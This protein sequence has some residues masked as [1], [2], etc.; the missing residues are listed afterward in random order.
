VLAAAA[1]V[2][3]PQVPL[4]LLTTAVQALAGILLPS[5]TVDHAAHRVTQAAGTLG[6]AH[7]VPGGAPLLPVRRDRRPGCPG[8]PDRAGLSLTRV[9][10]AVA[11]DAVIKA[12][13]VSQLSVGWLW[14]HRG[15]RLPG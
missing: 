6:L 10:L 14:R 2:L 4:G 8:G 1:V 12:W 15:A 7:A 3:I 13:A 9:T 5:A 11:A